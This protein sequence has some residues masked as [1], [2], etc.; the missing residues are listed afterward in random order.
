MKEF[1]SLGEFAQYLAT[2]EF[3]LHE[4][5][6]LGLEVVAKKIEKTAKDEIGVYQPAVG[7]FPAWSPLAESTMEDRAAKGYPENEP[8]LRDG[9]LR[10]SIT[11]EVEGHEAMI[12]SDSDIAVYQELGTGRIP[13][14]P[15]LGSAV[16]HDEKFML[17]TLG[18]AAVAAIGGTVFVKKT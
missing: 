5:L 17:G 9:K 12:G 2:R 16:V 7:P 3:T 8:L 1:K 6:H 11:H 15:F 18:E 10:D 14:R 13:P 4:A